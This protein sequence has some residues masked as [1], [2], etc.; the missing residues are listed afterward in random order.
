MEVGDRGAGRRALGLSAVAA[1]SMTPD[2]AASGIGVDDAWR[3]WLGLAYVAEQT[4][5]QIRII[6]HIG[7]SPLSQARCIANRTVK[8]MT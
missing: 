8:A 2:N 6:S 7:A 3:S 5:F 4:N 1:Y